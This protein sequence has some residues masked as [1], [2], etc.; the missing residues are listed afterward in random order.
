MTVTAAWGLLK[1]Q[2]WAPLLATSALGLTI[3]LAAMHMW[4]DGS[5]YAVHSI[6]IT[7][8]V[9]SLWFLQS[10]ELRALYG[11]EP[12]GQAVTA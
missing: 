2:P 1:L 3:V 9:A 11:S 8:G 5:A 7:L 6:R 4:M 12:R 10:S